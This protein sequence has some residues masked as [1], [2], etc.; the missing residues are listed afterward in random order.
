MGQLIATEVT[1]KS[2]KNLLPTMLLVSMM[3]LPA[4]SSAQ[5]LLSNP[6]FGTDL[7]S[8]IGVGWWSSEDCCGNIGS[9]TYINQDYGY[10]A[11]YI[12]RQCV[13]LPAADEAFDLSGYIYVPVGQSGDGWGKLG[14]VWY[15]LPGCA[16]AGFIGGEDAAS[17]FPG[18]SWQ[19]TRR[20]AIAPATAVSVY[21]T[22][23]N[24]KTSESGTFQVYVDAV[25]LVMLDKI[26]ADDFESGD[27]SAWAATVP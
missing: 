16:A 24:Q 8:W 23:T 20:R 7:S 19:S 25:S 18:S 21:V 13:E 22:A 4:V 11:R 10:S 3:L 5:E 14:L 6:S 1:M 2:G 15:S 27:T 26:F 9:A 17:V 12:V